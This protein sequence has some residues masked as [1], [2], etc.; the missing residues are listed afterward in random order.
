[1]KDTILIVDDSEL[2]RTS[3]KALFRKQYKIIEAENGQDAW[4]CINRE[5][6]SAVLLDLIMPVMD[7]IELLK[8]MR[9][10][11]QYSDIPV[12]IITSS[13]DNEKLVEAFQAGATDY[14]LKPF[15]PQITI[16]RVNNA[17]VA[18]RRMRRILEEEKNLRKKAEL[19][20]LTGLYNKITTEERIGK[21][22]A[23]GPNILCAFFLIDIDNFKKVNDTRGHVVGD[24]VLKAV[25]DLISSYF[26]TGDII[27][28]IGGDEFVAFMW[29]I[30]SR[31]VAVEKAEELVSIVRGEP[32]STPEDV[33]F[34]VG[35]SFNNG[36]DMKYSELYN[37]ADKALYQ[38]KR[39]I[40]GNYSV[41]T[42]ETLDISV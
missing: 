41:Y 1:M 34:S 11:D 31:K 3:L 26:R 19:D 13:E 15:H 25:A 12:V 22:L 38:V 33:T 29:N 39:N 7:G 40:K 17:L 10:M 4:N 8:K 6:V 18:N 23:A 37:Q 21:Q 32:H 20:L 30:P 28:R 2:I 35:I 14:I 16:F 9:Q 36:K 42:S 24:H 5:I 27:G